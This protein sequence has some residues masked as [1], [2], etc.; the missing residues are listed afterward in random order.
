M[1]STMFLNTM[2]SRVCVPYLVSLMQRWWASK[3]IHSYAQVLNNPAFREEIL[4][5]LSSLCVCVCAPGT[6][7]VKCSIVEQEN[8]RWTMRFNVPSLLLPSNNNCK[9]K[10]YVE[11]EPRVVDGGSLPGPS[12]LQTLGLCLLRYSSRLPLC[13]FPLL[14]SLLTPTHIVSICTDTNI[15]HTRSDTYSSTGVCSV[16]Q[17]HTPPPSCGIDRSVCDFLDSVCDLAHTGAPIS[18]IASYISRNHRVGALP[19]PLELQGIGLT[20]VDSHSLSLLDLGGSCR[21]SVTRETIDT[22]DNDDEAQ[23]KDRE[24][25]LGCS[26]GDGIQEGDPSLPAQLAVVQSRGQACD[27]ALR[28]MMEEDEGDQDEGGDPL[29]DQQVHRMVDEDEPEEFENQPRVKRLFGHAVESPFDVDHPPV[30]HT[31]PKPFYEFVNQ[32]RKEMTGDDPLEPYDAERDVGERGER[33]ERSDGRQRIKVIQ[34]EFGDDPQYLMQEVDVECCFDEAFLSD[35]LKALEGNCNMS[36]RVESG[37]AGEIL[38]VRFLQMQL[39]CEESKY[40]GLTMHWINENRESGKPFDIRLTKGASCAETSEE[41]FVEVKTTAS[42]D[43]SMFKMSHDEWK[44]ADN[45][46][47]NY[48]VYRVFGVGT[49]K[50]KVYHIGNPVLKWRRQQLALYIAM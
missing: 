34:H 35:T 22:A 40:Y 30:E 11:I 5:R 20:Q 18:T 41:L 42:D 48:E 43:R 26:H 19:S 9:H 10:L 24:S 2:L 13:F 3:D 47:Q 4:S 12:H 29:L 50:P 33:G 15:T 44:F 39:L 31:G 16:S 1:V 49:K 37:R 25:T 21:V 46:R 14:T 45:Q 36:T 6:L 17:T 32:R 8:T 28:V 38:V 7:Y 23:V 27:E